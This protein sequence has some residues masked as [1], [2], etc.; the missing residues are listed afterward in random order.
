VSWAP[1]LGSAV[2]AITVLWTLGYPEQGRTLSKSR[3]L[4]NDEH[5]F[6]LAPKTERGV[7]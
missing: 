1:H 4:A 2:P 6:P 7:L 5:G 3:G